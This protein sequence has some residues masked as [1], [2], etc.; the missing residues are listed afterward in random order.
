MM[1]LRNANMK[2]HYRRIR[3]FIPSF[4]PLPERSYFCS[5]MAK[6][7]STP[8]HLA[9]HVKIQSYDM[10]YDCFIAQM[11]LRNTNYQ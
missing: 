11:I 10:N 2:L 7:A 8:N 6:L 4:L 5:Q 1:S 9:E 3:E